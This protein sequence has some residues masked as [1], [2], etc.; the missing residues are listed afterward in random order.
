MLRRILSVLS[1]V[2][3]TLVST[4]AYGLVIS[5][6]VI[7]GKNVPVANARVSLIVPVHRP[8]GFGKIAAS[9]TSSDNGSFQMEAADSLDPQMMQLMIESDAHAIAQARVPVPNPEVTRKTIEMGPITLSSPVQLRTQFLDPAGKPV[10]GMKVFLNLLFDGGDLKEN[11]GWWSL[12]VPEEARDR[13]TRTTDAEGFCTFEMIP[14]VSRVRLGILDERFVQISFENNITVGMQPRTTA[15]PFHLR[16][17]SSISGKVTYENSGK[18]AVK[19]LVGVQATNRNMSAG[20]GSAFTDENGEYHIKQLP[21]GEYNV[22][23]SEPPENDKDW[24]AAAIEKLGL[25]RAHQLERQNLTLIKGSI[26]TGEVILKDTGEG[27]ADVWVGAHTPA[28]PKSG[29]SI[30]GARTAKDGSFSLRVPPGSQYLYLAQMV[31]DGYLEPRPWEGE[32]KAGETRTID[33][34]IQRDPAP[35]VAGRVV[36]AQNNPVADAI[37]TAYR[38]NEMFYQSRVVRSTRDGRFGFRALPKGSTVTAKKGDLKSEPAVTQLENNDLTLVVEKELVGSLLV[39]VVDKGG[40][41]VKGAEVHLIT[42]APKGAATD[43]LVGLT[44]EQGRFAIFNVPIANSYRITIEA[45]G[46]L[47]NAEDVTPALESDNERLVKITLK[48]K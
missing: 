46:F 40:V 47:W 12:Q 27:V 38:P 44:N 5:G 39:T 37:V 32:I 28:H 34:E 1:I 23:L 8:S 30:N 20:Y 42:S 18:P 45:T 13:Y 33:I 41:A 25:G 3:A 26:I 2:L 36:D 14:P 22:M 4:R 7:D 19:A 21:E 9:V 43:K 48:R 31:P 17:A 35:P 10:E 16:E 11:S 29:A 24:T 15:P 6:K